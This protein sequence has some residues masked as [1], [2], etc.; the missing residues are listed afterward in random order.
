MSSTFPVA[1]S[2]TLGIVSVIAIAASA[3]FIYEAVTDVSVTTTHG[4]A[5]SYSAAMVLPNTLLKITHQDATE[6]RGTIRFFEQELTPNHI[7][8]DWQSIQNGDDATIRFISSE[9][10]PNTYHDVLHE[11]AGFEI[12]AN[13]LVRP[14]TETASTPELVIAV[15]EIDVAEP[16]IITITPDHDLSAEE[17]STLTNLFTGYIGEYMVQL[18]IK[19]GSIKKIG[20]DDMVVNSIHQYARLFSSLVGRTADNN[21]RWDIIDDATDTT[22]KVLTQSG[23]KKRASTGSHDAAEKPKPLQGAADGERRRLQLGSCSVNWW[24]IGDGYC[25]SS[26]NNA[27]CNWD[28]GD[29][30]SQTCD[31]GV[32][33]ED[34]DGTDYYGYT[35]GT[36]GYNCVPGCSVSD[37]SKL[38]DGQCDKTGGYNTEACGYDLGD[39]CGD[40]CEDA[41][42]SCGSNGYDCKDSSANWCSRSRCG[43]DCLGLCGADCSCWTWTC[44]DCHCHG[45]C[46][47]HDTYCSCGSMWG[48]WCLNVFWV[49]CDNGDL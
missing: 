1:K 7:T 26:A 23:L 3:Y 25:D 32:D 21:W 14:G 12:Y 28:N 36:A 18:S 31:S 34:N 8:F 42:Y 4:S 35:C 43:N 46:A 49:N 45:E 41:A 6:L 11:F 10:I 5:T 16:T 30:C 29:C 27:G 22:N 47:E 24:W 39:C 38:G 15:S 48:F 9:Y 40:T 33:W 37:P 20:A 2:I 13:T 17:E 44:G 19:L